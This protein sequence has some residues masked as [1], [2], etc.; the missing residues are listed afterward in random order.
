M[1]K[2]A[3]EAWSDLAWAQALNAWG[4]PARAARAVATPTARLAREVAALRAELA[5]LAD[6]GAPWLIEEPDPLGSL[7]PADSQPLPPGEKLVRGDASE[8]QLR[9]D[10]AARSRAA[11][12]APGEIQ[13]EGEKPSLLSAGS[14]A[15]RPTDARSTRGRVGEIDEETLVAAAQRPVEG[16]AAPKD[17]LERWAGVAPNAREAAAGRA[18]MARPTL[19]RP[20]GSSVE[21][22]RER[23]MSRPTGDLTERSLAAARGES[24][25]ATTLA[26]SLSNRGGRMSDPVPDER[27]MSAPPRSPTTHAAE[28]QG[29]VRASEGAPAPQAVDL[30][31][32]LTARWWEAQRG[33]SPAPPA[34]PAA[35]AVAPGSQASQATNPGREEPM[36]A[37]RPPASEERSPTTA[38]PGWPVAEEAHVRW[39]T[40]TAQNTI[41]LTVQAPP[42]VGAL[43]ADELA[44]LLD[45]ILRREAQRHGIPLL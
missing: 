42:V 36:F 18:S 26:A 34:R 22:D 31:T 41:H 6:L 45:R 44:D 10:P 3:R 12:S 21:P 9:S 4:A 11:S 32:R 24:L 37:G 5:D 28:T 19:Q 1:A 39:A 38:D 23:Q 16:A 20:V 8:R 2:V 43:D 35:T 13:A 30:L 25:P 7:T 40:P 15:R 29:R 27:S 17:L 33:A 14:L